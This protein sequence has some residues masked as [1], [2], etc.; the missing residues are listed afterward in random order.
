MELSVNGKEYDIKVDPRTNLL[1]V[2]RESL[3]LT[4]SK[5]GCGEGMC[6]ACTV[7]MDGAPVRSCI[8]P[9]ASTSGKNITTIEGLNTSNDLH[10]IQKA[11]LKVDVFQCGYCASGMIMSSVAL[12]QKNPKPSQHEIEESLHGNIC[13]CGTYPRI[14]KAIQEASKG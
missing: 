2:L 4:G 10:P 14:L 6:G 1:E 8:T 13:R 5:Y 3:D 9:I 7:L 12:L 11:F